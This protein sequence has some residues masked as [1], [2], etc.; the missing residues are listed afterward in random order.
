MFVI[1]HSEMKTDGDWREQHIYS[2]DVEIIT[3]ADGL[4]II[5]R[6]YTNTSFVVEVHYRK[7]EDSC[8][9]I[10]RDTTAWI[11]SLNQYHAESSVQSNGDHMQGCIVRIQASHG[12]YTA[13][14]AKDILMSVH[15]IRP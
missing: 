7:V 1:V 3:K 15:F 5:F 11:S 4:S 8:L 2:F 9:L 13:L 10:Y 12:N 14:Y 6:G